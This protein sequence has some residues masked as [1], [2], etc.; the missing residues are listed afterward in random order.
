MRRQQ[1]IWLQEHTDLG[2]LPTMAQTDPTSGVVKFI[3]Y[4]RTREVSFQ[5]QAV[6][7][8]AGK[9]RNSV[10]LAKQGF[11]VWALEYIEAALDAA[12]QLAAARAPKARIHFELT[13]IDETWPLQS[14]SIDVAID[15]FAS[16]DIET[17]EG[18]VA[19]RDELFRTLK[20][21]GYALINVCSA[22]DEWEKELIRD[23]PGTEPNSTIWPANGKFQKDYDEAELREFYS[24]FSILELET[25]KKPAHKLG[26]DGTATNL[27]LVVQ[28]PA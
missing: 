9:G 2:S 17:L 24:Q 16:I 8:G 1:A 12:R 5:G 10:Y 28:K 27:W 21:G 6:D 15:S 13:A 26:R 4:L 23:H 25:I 22:E 14:E 3:D 11:E 18:R 19:C 7:I 20:P